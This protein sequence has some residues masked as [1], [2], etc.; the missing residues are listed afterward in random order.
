MN[1]NIVTKES[2]S[3]NK[4]Q[5]NGNIDTLDEED[6]YSSLSNQSHISKKNVNEITEIR[7]KS[8]IKT[9]KSTLNLTEKKRNLHFEDMN[10][11]ELLENFDILKSNKLSNSQ[12]VQFLKR[13]IYTKELLNDDLDTQRITDIV[14]SQEPK[15]LKITKDSNV[16][17]S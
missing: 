10:Y 11:Y 9:K 16:L 6:G 13:L 5:T 7:R 14:K 12:K 4:M 1:E 3:V 2:C 15:K 17:N 8:D